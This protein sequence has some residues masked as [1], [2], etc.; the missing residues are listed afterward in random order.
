[1]CVCLRAF[2]P[3]GKREKRRGLHTYLNQPT[4]FPAKE[5]TNKTHIEG[6]AALSRQAKKSNHLL[7]FIVLSVPSFPSSHPPPPSFISSLPP[8]PRKRTKIKLFIHLSYLFSSSPFP[9]THTVPPPPPSFLPHSTLL[10]HLGQLRTHLVNRR[11]VRILGTRVLQDRTPRHKEISARLSDLLDVGHAHT[12]I[13]LQADVIARLIDHLTGLTKLDK[14]LGDEGLPTKARVHG[15]E[16]DD[17]NLVQDVLGHGE[18]GGGVEDQAGLAAFALDE[19][20]GSVDVVGGLRV[21][22]DEGGA[23][24]GKVGDDAVDGGDHQMH[25]NGGGDAVIAQGLADHGANRQVGDVVVVHHIEVHDVSAGG[26]DVV[27]FL[28]ELG[29]VSGED[30]GGNPEVLLGGHGDAAA[31]VGA[32]GRD[33]KAVGDRGEGNDAASNKRKASHFKGEG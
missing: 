13:D 10:V 20:Q 3:E 16:E 27:H 18:G 30:G 2:C 19:L 15:H 12:A 6:E 23:G 14:G 4:T 9:V 31:G 17:I 21:E 33:D 1:M 26:Q 29:K 28:P 25:V 7:R 11:L 5:T 24:I 22:G 8:Y 32:G